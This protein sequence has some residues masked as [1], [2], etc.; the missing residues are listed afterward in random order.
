ME[1]AIIKIYL[2]TQIPHE[3]WVDVLPRDNP[4]QSTFAYTFI[5]LL[6]I[7]SFSG[8]FGGKNTNL[9][10]NEFNDANAHIYYE[11]HYSSVVIDRA[12]N[13]QWQETASHFNDEY[14][15]DCLQ[16]VGGWC[17]TTVEVTWS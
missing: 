13:Q 3:I 12:G 4:I 11:S 1:P 10:L 9:N 8:F 5:A 6:I 16:G 15:P 17:Y 2:I 14:K 7:G